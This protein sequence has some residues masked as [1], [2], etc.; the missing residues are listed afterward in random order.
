[1]NERENMETPRLLEE[2]HI[3]CEV[4]F[5]Y[6]GK[7]YCIPHFSGDGIHKIS[8][9]EFCRSVYEDDSPED[10]VENARVGDEKFRDIW[11]SA[12]ILCVY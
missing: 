8:F 1:M 2:P 9:F 7:Q 11:K 12:E 3:G 5:A 6:G 10:F 4:E